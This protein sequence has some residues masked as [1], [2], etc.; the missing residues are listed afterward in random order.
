MRT[1]P[2]DMRS[3]AV[4]RIPAG[5]HDPHGSLLLSRS[6]CDPWILLRSFCDPWTDCRSFSGCIRNRYSV[7]DT[8]Q[9]WNLVRMIFRKLFKKKVREKIRI[10]LRKDYAFY[11]RF[12]VH[13]ILRIFSG[14]FPV[15]FF[16]SF[17]MELF[18]MN[19]RA[20]RGKISR[21]DFPDLPGSFQRFL[22][23]FSRTIMKKSE[24]FPLRIFPKIKCV[25]I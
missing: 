21:R 15:F 20:V 25:I 24:G 3:N 23:I 12:F 10:L 9:R 1:N 22:R 2:S 19:H 7:T 18:D 16:R 13:I 5:L 17:S 4:R 11:F 14:T 8:D 6:V